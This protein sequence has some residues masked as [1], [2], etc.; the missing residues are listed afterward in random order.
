MTFLLLVLAITLM[1]TAVTGSFTLVNLL[2][3]AVIAGLATLLIRSR[4]DR[5]HLGRRLW[6][7]VS[8]AG[9]FL[10][11][12]ALSASRVA[13]LVLAPD[14]KKRLAPAIFAYPL[15]VR[16]DVEITLLA[17]LVTLTPGTLS[18][19]VS[20][21]RRTLYIHALEMR[22]KDAAIAAIRDGFEARIIAV[23]AQ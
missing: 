5:P 14:L 1:W 17:N 9:L 8:L 18:V 10:Y 7:A 2:L 21:D 13:L 19:D 12:L 4:I 22:D 23:F 15:T 16:S 11:E 20:E 6:L 3:G